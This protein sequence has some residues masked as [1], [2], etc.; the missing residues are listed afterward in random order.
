MTRIADVRLPEQEMFAQR[1]DVRSIAQQLKIPRAVH[2]IADQDAPANPVITQHDFLID[3]ACDVLEHERFAVGVSLKIASRVHFDA[4]HLELRRRQRTFVAGRSGARQM[5]RAHLRL[6]EQ[7]RDQPVGGTAVLHA[8]AD[9]VNG[10]IEGLHGV[11]H[12][13]AALAMYAECFGKRNV[14]PDADRHHYKIRRDFET[15]F[16]AHRPHAIVADDRFR[17]MFEKKIQT[18]AFEFAL[19]QTG[20]RCVQLTLHECCQEVNHGHVHAALGEPVGRLKT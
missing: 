11:V 18:A 13:D 14:R 10:G 12:D 19:Q 8:L 2:R 20:R 3:A 16:E 9:R 17:L 5:I 6:F 1:G 15:V 4:C 7:R